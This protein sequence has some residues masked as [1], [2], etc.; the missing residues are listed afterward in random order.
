MG[1]EGEAAGA[2][3]GGRALEVGGKR[4]VGGMGRREKRSGGGVNHTHW[5]DD[6]RRRRGTE[7]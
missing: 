4:T 3:G 2:A 5:H 7:T 1:E 6:V